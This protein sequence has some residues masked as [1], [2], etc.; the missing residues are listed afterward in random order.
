MKTRLTFL[1]SLLVAFLFTSLSV[2]AQD[3]SEGIKDFSFIHATDTH[4][5][6]HI[7]MPSS[8]DKER[9]YSTI[10]GI[11]NIKEIL[12]QPYNITAPAPSFIIHTG[13]F[14]EFGYPG[15][16]WKVAEEYFKGI[17][18]PLYI[19]YGN[20][21]MTW[22]SD[23]KYLKEKFGGVNYSFDYNGIHFIGLCTPSL[24]EPVPSVGEEML[25]FLRNDL[26]KIKFST[27]I[28]IFFH[29]PLDSNEF[30][31]D[32]DVDR[33]L[34]TVKYYNV[35]LMLYGHGHSPVT[36]VFDGISGA[37]GGS[38]YKHGGAPDGGYNIV[39]IKNNNLYVA[40]KKAE[41]QSA[42]KPMVKKEIPQNSSYPKIAIESPAEGEIVSAEKLN[43][44]AAVEAGGRKIAGAN[45]SIDGGDA[46][47][48]V[49]S[50]DKAEFSLPLA[51]I[52][53]GAHSIKIKFNTIEKEA[54]TK[55]VFFLV[56]NKSRSG[57]G[58]LKWQFKTNGA[59]KAKPMVYAGILYV[60]TNDGF[61]YAL[62][63]D[64]GKLKWKFNSEGEIAGSVALYKTGFW[65][66]KRIIFG[67]GSGK[68]FA[69]S[70]KGKLIWSN[71]TGHAVYS[72]VSVDDEGVA[73]VG[74]NGGELIALD[75]DTGKIIWKNNESNLA[76]ESQP[77]I[78]KDKVYVGS[79]SGY[80]YCVDKKTGKTLWKSPGPK[81]QG[82]VI[83]YYAPADNPPVVIEDKIFVAD[84]GYELGNYK[85][86]G[87]YND[88]ITSG[89]SAISLSEDGKSLYART[90][91]EPFKKFDLDGKL[92]WDSPA[93]LGRLPISPTE[94]GNFVYACSN[95][96][97]LYL[98]DSCC[99]EIRGEYQVTPK[100]YVMSEIAVDDGIAFIST[101]DGYIK[102]VNFC[103]AKKSAK[104]K[105]ALCH[106][107]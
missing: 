38:T 85:T 30:C 91:S 100:L 39:C 34:D 45:C 82:R 17:N 84:R 88:T 9:S 10:Q 50:G 71:D 98:I 96:G 67:S 62:D 3:S 63:A 87:T 65:N 16:V 73:Y 5:S 20:H 56:E 68:V 29:H 80:L 59:S 37:E 2:V 58:N 22:V 15:V 47:E 107:K 76:I 69:V 64:N 18:L 79:W 51:N 103:G 78:M 12:L 53:N 97:N 70:S 99:G 81:N 92:I 41:S 49:L 101:T 7:T 21:D 44:K 48:M 19:E 105:C 42:E 33:L 61:L 24:Q 23:T 13:D 35:I 72:P 40:Y 43:I 32:Y 25:V 106:K 86:D 52:K 36:H 1:C 31:S 60:G 102:A 26:G 77:I 11:N 74:N 94:S 46:V 14:T 54:F 104:E 27:P 90:L 6:P 89:C 55:S 93:K 4:I 75:A 28:I 57:Q 66:K 95:S 83:T 8:L